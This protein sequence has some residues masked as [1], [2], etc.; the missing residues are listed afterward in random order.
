MSSQ[1]H[2]G[3]RVLWTPLSVAWAPPSAS[4][5]F[6]CEAMTQALA[7][8]CDQHADPFECADGL[9]VYNEVLDEFGLP[10]H[11]GGASYVLIAFCP[12]CGTRLPES[13][14]D[15]WF[16]EVEAAGYT[17]DTLPPEYLSATWRHR[18]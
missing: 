5:V 14:R 11:D 6:C 3:R 2:P 8:D 9:M 12:W 10:V 13:Q 15:R 17:D 1:L 18:R 16:D 7:F 4:A